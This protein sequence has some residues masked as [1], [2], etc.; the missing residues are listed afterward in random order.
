LKEKIRVLIELQNCDNRI[1][2][3][4][5]KKGLGPAKIQALAE[6]LETV[7]IGFQEDEERLEAI[8]KERRSIEQEVE[9]MENKLVKGNEKLSNIKSNKE[10]SAALKEI[11]QL[12]KKRGQ[13][14]DRLLQQMEELEQLTAACKANQARMK[15]LQDRFARD[16]E[17]V[18]TEIEALDKDLKAMDKERAAITRKVEPEF[19][20]QYQLVRARIGHMAV[21][22][23]IGGVCK[24]C[25]MGI[26]P[27]MFNELMRCLELTS[28]PHC[29]RIIYWG[30][31]ER[32][33]DLTN[34]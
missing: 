20:S 11:E 23:V 7:S 34:H 16:K 25:N 14:E 3:I 2:E 31:D 24:T 15:D 8:Q 26:P 33:R 29:N 32:F 4:E 28:C 27:Q 30:D 22:P 17:E 12:K 21:S 10:Y 18:R 5:K 9:D 1:R 6:E 19:L 13:L